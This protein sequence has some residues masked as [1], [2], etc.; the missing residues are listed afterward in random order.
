MDIPTGQTGKKE[1]SL[2][3]TKLE[4]DFGRDRGLGRCGRRAWPMLPPIPPLHRII[5][6]GANSPA[7]PSK[8]RNKNNEETGGKERAARSLV[9]SPR[10][11][12]G[13]LSPWSPHRELVATASRWQMR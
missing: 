1:R 9:F 11:Q 13:K 5:L 6:P 12:V 7:S 2:M 4:L 8:S 3:Q 10:T